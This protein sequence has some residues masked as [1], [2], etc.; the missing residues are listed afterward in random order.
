MESPVAVVDQTI[1]NVV[2]S[3]DGNVEMIDAPTVAPAGPSKIKI[4]FNKPI[5]SQNTATTAPT[6]IMK[7]PND[8]IPEDDEPEPMPLQPKEKKPR[9]AQSQLTEYPKRVRGTETA[10]ICTI[11]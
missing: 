6:V 9:I 8:V 11:M 1:T 2:S 3:I 4:T 5:L 10:G 7:D